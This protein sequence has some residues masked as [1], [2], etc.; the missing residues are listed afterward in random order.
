MKK[1]KLKPEDV[2]MVG[3]SLQSDMKPAE[4]AGIRGILKDQRGRREYKEK[5]RYLSQIPQ[6]I[7]G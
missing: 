4:E 5:I 7:E 3:D 2:V 1:H 6:H